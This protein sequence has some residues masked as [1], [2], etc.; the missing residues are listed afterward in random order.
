MI[1]VFDLYNDFKGLVN[2]FQGGFYQP[3]STF[4]RA[5]NN[6]HKELWIKWTN[7]AEKSQEARDNLAWALK[8]ENVIVTAA[9]SYYGIL[10]P[11]VDY[12]RFASAKI[13]WEKKDDEVKC[14]P[15]INVNKGKCIIGKRNKNGIMINTYDTTISQEEITEAYYDKLEESDVELI[16]EQRWSACIKHLSKSPTIENPKMRQINQ[17]WNVA[18]R[19]VSMVILNYYINPVDAKFAYATT[20]GD[21]QTGA[22]DEIVYDA[23][24]STQ[25]PW[26]DSVKNEFL[27]RL[28]ERFSYFTHDQFLAQVIKIK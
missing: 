22:G 15:S 26:P 12:G 27:W 17:G 3:Q 6:I 23:K 11:P 20:P 28:G 7:E 8:S 21:V 14:K 16:D 5:A 19:Q 10:K 13:L 2:T 24:N 1:D 18:P 9:N 4:I 25:F